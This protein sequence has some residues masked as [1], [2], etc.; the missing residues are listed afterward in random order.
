[1]W[2]PRAVEQSSARKP[3]PRKLDKQPLKSNNLKMESMKN[4]SYSGDWSDEQSESMKKWLGDAWKNLDGSEAEPDFLEYMM[5]MIKNRKTMQEVL[6]ELSD[7]GVADD[8]A[9]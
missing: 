8:K 2:G 3:L 5:V 9:R 4:Y 1:M 6:S 7:L